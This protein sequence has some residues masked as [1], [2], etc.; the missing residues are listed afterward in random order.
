MSI[1]E[2]VGVVVL[3]CVGIALEFFVGVIRRFKK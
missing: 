3:V 1:F 2:I